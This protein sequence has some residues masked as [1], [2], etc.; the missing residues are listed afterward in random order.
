MATRPMPRPPGVIQH[1]HAYRRR[2]GVARWAD[3][4]WTVSLMPEARARPPATMWGELARYPG[5]G[6]A[7]RAVWMHMYYGA[8]VS[9]RLE[10]ERA[11]M[12][13]RDQI[14]L[15]LLVGHI[16]RIDKIS[17]ALYK[18]VGDLLYAH[19]PTLGDYAM[20]LAAALGE[21]EVMYKH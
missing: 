16:R 10:F 13:G 15:D 9:H 12:Y 20:V 21:L 1:I 11:V 18:R 4:Y 6:Q 7:I 5:V 8:G 3:W 19:D 17:P 2:M 14:A